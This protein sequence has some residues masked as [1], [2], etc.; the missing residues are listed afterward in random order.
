MSKPRLLACVLLSGL[1]V[2][3]CAKIGG[4]R[5]RT[6]VPSGPVS[7]GTAEPGYLPA[8]AELVIRANEPIEVNTQRDVAGRTFSA[9]IARDIVDADGRVIVPAGSPAE[10]R[11]VNSSTGGAGGSPNLELTVS[12]I[13]VNGRRY[14]IEAAP[15]KASSGTGI[16]ANRR[17]A[18]MVGGGA[19]L[20]TLIGAVAGGGT[21]AAVGA[22]AG[23]AAGGAAQVLTRGK[24]V[25]VPAETVMTFR[26]E[27]PIR[28]RGYQRS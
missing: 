18:T 14:E 6:T 17:T 9:Q 23:A 28:L 16:G 4:T 3:S 19:V 24:E 10:L 8:G 12:S 5:S 25:R 1:L 26:L 2:G 15:E 7:T 11:V 13:T 22:A 21:G 27:S 20:G